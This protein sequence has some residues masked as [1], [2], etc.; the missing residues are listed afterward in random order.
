MNHTLST[1]ILKSS[2]ISNIKI[3][4]P[5]ELLI[6]FSSNMVLGPQVEC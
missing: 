3:S 4:R 1:K 5:E 2:C 6:A